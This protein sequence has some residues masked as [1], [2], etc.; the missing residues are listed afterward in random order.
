MLQNR[1]AI[2]IG[3]I[4]NPTQGLPI[5]VTELEH[6]LLPLMHSHHID[7]IGTVPPEAEGMAQLM[8]SSGLQNRSPEMR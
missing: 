3:L 8:Q 1:G 7:R 5:T 2:A 6:R 4:P